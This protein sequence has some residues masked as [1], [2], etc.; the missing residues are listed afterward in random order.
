MNDPTH[1][2]AS[3][4][5]MLPAAFVV[6]GLFMGHVSLASHLDRLV[7]RMDTLRRDL[8]EVKRDLHT[9]CSRS[10]VRHHRR[11]AR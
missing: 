4:S 2:L 10:D 7:M 1:L 5:A 9:L 8:R 11:E 6:G 3:F